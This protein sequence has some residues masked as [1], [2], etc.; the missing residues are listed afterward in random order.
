MNIK[1]SIL[2][3]TYQHQDYIEQAIESINRQVDLPHP[4]EVVVFD[5]HSTDQ[6]IEKCRAGLTM[7]EQVRIHSHPQNIGI[8]KNYQQAFPF[9]RGEMIAVLEG[10]DIWYHPHKIAWQYQYLLDHP[11][12]L[13]CSHPFVMMTDEQINR[14]TEK[15][16]LSKPSGNLITAEALIMDH[17]LISNFST[18]MY[19]KSALDQLPAALFETKS[20]DWIINVTLAG[21]GEAVRL[22]QPLSI[23]RISPKGAW[24]GLSDQRKLE[25]WIEMMPIYDQILEHRYTET[26]QAKTRLLSAELNNLI[27]EPALKT[28]KNW[29][30][31]IKQKWLAT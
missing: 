8:T 13:L 20:Y 12:T 3:I 16:M 1:L 11:N 4:Y 26:F 2:L 25:G 9:C 23:Y 19:R 18:C 27:H 24:T 31:A 21:M 29:W 30:Q 10:D 17:S 5:D 22:E 7:H 14:Y 15:P 6:T 28:K